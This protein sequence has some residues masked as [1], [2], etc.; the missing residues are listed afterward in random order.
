MSNDA[1]VVKSEVSGPLV[2]LSGCLA[3]LTLPVSFSGAAIAT[4]AIGRDLGGSAVALTWVTNAFMLTF[5]SLLLTAGTL[6]DRFGRKRIFL[7]GIA[8]FVVFSLAMSF[9]S[10]VWIFDLLRAGQGIGAAAAL[11]GGSAAMAQEFDGQA[12]IRAFSMLGTT[13]GIGLAF[14]PVFAGLLINSFGWRS[15]FLFSAAIGIAALVLG[16]SRLCET[17]DPQSTRHDWLGVVTFTGALSLFTFAI[18]EGPTSGWSSPL[19]L[20]ALA[21]TLVFASAFVVAENTVERPMLDLSLFRYPRFVGVQ[22]LPVATCYSYVV[23]LIILPLRLVGIE[24]YSEVHAGLLMMAL[25][26]PML[27]V[28]AAAAFS[29]RWIAP[30]MLSGVG[31]LIAATGMFLLGRAPVGAL[32]DMVAAMLL[33]GLGSGI[34]WGLMDGLA[35]SV[36]PKERAGMAAGIFN[37]S[38]VANEGVA[39]AIV[40][41]GLSMLTAIHIRTLSAQTGVISETD[42]SEVGQ[43]LATGDL[44]TAKAM[45]PAFGHSMLVD[46]YLTAFGMITEVLAVITIASAAVT[47]LLLGSRKH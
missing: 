38:K 4:P 25:S 23:L 11:A 26:A 30:G 12:R 40:S 16:A 20:G 15:I 3:A 17:A 34:P 32:S 33:I 42:A 43:R 14:G 47:F 8:L 22:L 2:I 46:S 45:L 7:S 41:A 29:S 19:I 31:L 39:L 6:A 28:P 21:G 9:V 36:V 35:V 5:G 24:G 27:I 18:I 37:T 13:F 44:V 1:V 10:N